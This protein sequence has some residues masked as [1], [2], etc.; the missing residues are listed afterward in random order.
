MLNMNQWVINVMN[1]MNEGHERN[2]YNRYFAAPLAGA[3]LLAHLTCKP[4]NN[5]HIHKVHLP[6]PH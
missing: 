4:K 1:N 5:A 3:T 6:V 2:R